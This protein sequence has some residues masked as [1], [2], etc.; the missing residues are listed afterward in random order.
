MLTLFVPVFI[1]GVKVNPVAPF[2]VAKVAGTKV[3]VLAAAALDE[4]LKSVLA[5]QI[6][7]AA[8]PEINI[9]TSA[10]FQV[11]TSLFL[12]YTKVSFHQ[13]A[14]SSAKSSIALFLVTLRFDKAIDFTCLL[15]DFFGTTFSVF[16]ILF[17]I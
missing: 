15:T 5:L 16:F 17:Y 4:S 7:A 9:K 3:R 6:S 12:T 2:V 13:G 11:A 1:V 10:P 8:K 14:I